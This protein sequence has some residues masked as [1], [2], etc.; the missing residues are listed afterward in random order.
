MPRR[1]Y[2]PSLSP[3]TSMTS[4]PYCMSLSSHI[5]HVFPNQS[6]SGLRNQCWSCTLC[7][8]VYSEH[9]TQT[10]FICTVDSISRRNMVPT[11]PIKFTTVN[12]VK[13]LTRTIAGIYSTIHRISQTIFYYQYMTFRRY[14]GVLYRILSGAMLS[15]RTKGDFYLFYDFHKVEFWRYSC[16]TWVL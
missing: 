1:R 14:A 12:I 7:L 4:C 3:G 11:L 5:C 9:L 15:I 10:I 8:S 13:L 16:D 6:R 2:P